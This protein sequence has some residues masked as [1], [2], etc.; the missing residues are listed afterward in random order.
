M[1]R[2]RLYLP[3]PRRFCLNKDDPWKELQRSPW[4]KRASPP[5]HHM[6]ASPP[7]F[8]PGSCLLLFSP[9]PQRLV[10]GDLVPVTSGLGVEQALSA[11][12]WFC[13]LT[14]FCGRSK[15]FA[16]RLEDS[17]AA[18]IHLKRKQGQGVAG[19]TPAFKCTPS[20]CDVSSDN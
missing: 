5:N 2:T 14:K 10:E 1:I 16:Q 20:M 6:K 11:K 17:P 3:T 19:K 9:L 4:I 12:C 8:S 13:P 15:F 7:R 18:P